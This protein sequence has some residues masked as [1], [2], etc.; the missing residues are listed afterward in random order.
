VCTFPNA[1]HAVAYTVMMINQF[2]PSLLKHVDA[3]EL[4]MA[5]LRNPQ[6]IS[7]LNEILSRYEEAEKAIVTAEA[8]L[9]EAKRSQAEAVECILALVGKAV[10]VPDDS[11]QATMTTGHC[12]PER[13][14][15][16]LLDPRAQA[17]RDSARIRQMHAEWTRHPSERQYDREM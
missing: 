6:A 8:M 17:A 12:P 4:L 1:Q 5:L 11:C 15:D 2:P 13:E 3:Q 10:T 7:D 14:Q 16:E 9:A